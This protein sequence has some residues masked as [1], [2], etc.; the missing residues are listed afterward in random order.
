MGD[1]RVAVG[2]GVGLVAVVAVGC[3]RGKRPD[4]EGGIVTVSSSA[5]GDS[6]EFDDSGGE[7]GEFPPGER[8]TDDRPVVTSS[9]HVHPIVG[10]TLLALADGETI[11]A[12]DAD[13]DSVHVVHLPTASETGTIELEAGSVPGRVAQDADGGVHVVLRRAGEVATIDPATATVVERRRVC[14]NPRGIAHD[15]ATDELLVACAGGSVVTLAPDGSR[16]AFA[17]SRDLRDV[18]AVDGRRFVSRFR[19]AEVYQVD[20]DGLI[21]DATQALGVEMDEVAFEA[22]TAWRTVGTPDGGWLMV[23]QAAA[24]R[25]I[26]PPGAGGH[27]GWGSP[28]AVPLCNG[29]V[30]TALTL[31]T[32][33]GDRSSSGKLRAA[34]LAVDVAIS[35]A[36]NDVAIAIAGQS[37]PEA[38]M[39]PARRGVAVLGVDDFGPDNAEE[40]VDLDDLGTRGQP[41]AVDFVPGTRTLAI[42]SREPA[43]LTAHDLDDG[44]SQEIPLF[45][46]SRFDTGHDMFHQ[47]GGGGIACASCHPEGTDD[48]RVWDLTAEDPRRTQPLNTDLAGTAP[49]HWNGGME[50]MTAIVD[51]VMTDAM[52]SAIQSRDRAAALE[53]YVMDIA[54]PVPLRDASEAAVVAG[55]QAFVD[56]GCA[57]CHA[58]DTF[59][60]N[61]GVTIH[62]IEGVQVP[63]LRGV[64][65]RPPYGIDGRNRDLYQTVWDMLD[66]SGT[67]DRATE[68]DAEA[69][70]AFLESL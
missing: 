44:S 66:I 21:V 40:C 15:A 4:N 61:Q 56:L 22:S 65:L 23:H 16:R 58:G 24:T 49:F 35:D 51:E 70:V 30:A 53:S 25:E 13:R 31:A 38:P 45:G 57:S 9:S 29:V 11:V 17:V 60:G 14:P 69:L 67:T 50:D 27:G 59:S 41:V 42:L 48:G 43:V 26:V 68:D 6:G 55:E 28:P 46:E 62:G 47:D 39:G 8:P 37:D 18:I 63:P 64:A 5:S 10:G 33:A 19:T 7:T 34:V 36:G 52:T 3:S 54:P 12:A 20:R 1:V 32:E 2:W